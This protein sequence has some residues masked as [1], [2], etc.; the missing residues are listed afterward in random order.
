MCIRDRW[1]QRRVH[2]EFASMDPGKKSVT[3][4]EFVELFEAQGST[5]LPFHILDVREPSEIVATNLPASNKNG[6][7]MAKVNIPVGT[8]TSSSA[9]DAISAGLSTAKPIY[10]MC[11]GGVRSNRAAEYLRTIGF[12]TIN[13][14]GGI[15]GL[16]GKLAGIQVTIHR[17]ENRSF[18]LSVDEGLFIQCKCTFTSRSILQTRQTQR[19]RYN[20]EFTQ[21]Q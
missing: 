8:V 7:A 10:C 2:G 16:A 19:D 9:E 20:L 14:E 1:Y 11:A 5:D 4:D 3:S 15:K 17:Y 21:I 6:V 13:I 12:T 18:Q